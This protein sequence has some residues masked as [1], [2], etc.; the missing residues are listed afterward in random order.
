MK[1]LAS[2]LLLVLCLSGCT[3]PLT[4]AQPQSFRY[5]VLNIPTPASP[6]PVS[7]PRMG[8]V[9]VTMPGYL[10]RPQIV[11]READGV[12]IRVNDFDR[13]GEELGTGVSR[14][15]CES[16]TAHG[17]PAISLRTG[18][19]VDNRLLLEVLRFDGT[20]GKTVT[21]DAIWTIQKQGTILRT[22]HVILEEQAGDDLESMVRAQS[23]LIF[24]LGAAI[25]KALR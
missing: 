13:W 4:T 3:L 12:N 2:A 6:Q 22:G 20:P 18:A 8:V 14:L 16:L 5:Y 1:A 10:N 11:T 25:D 21:L 23:K 17:H 7:G 9:P 24:D 15:L 19:H